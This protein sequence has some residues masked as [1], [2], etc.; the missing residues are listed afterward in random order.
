[1]SGLRPGDLME[2][3][4][5]ILTL[6]SAVAVVIFF[7][8]LAVY[9]VLISKTLEEIGGRGDSYLA[10]LRLGLRAIEQETGHLPGQVVT[11]NEGLTEVANGLKQINDHL[12]NTI[13]AAVKQELYK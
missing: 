5:V 1:M 11:L 2:S 12:V 7:G 8:A 3:S 13:Y 6:I 9:L 10:K 4:F